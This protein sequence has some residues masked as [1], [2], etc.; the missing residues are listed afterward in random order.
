MIEPTVPSWNSSDYQLL[1]FGGGRK[2]ERLGGIILDRPCPA[3]MIHSAARPSDWPLAR[4]KLDSEGNIV[5]GEVPRGNWCAVFG[6]V[7]FNL[8]ITPFGHVGLFP[9]QAPNWR[10]LSQAATKISTEFHRP[11]RSLNLFA[12]TGGTTL[13]LA[14][15]GA[16]VVHVDAS[17][18]AVKWARS[19]AVSS[20]LNE[21]PIRW[22]VEDARK[23]VARELKRGN[24]YDIV[25]LDP[26]SYG[27]GPS[28]L[29]WSIEQDLQRLLNDCIKLL[30]SPRGL[31]LLTAH[32]DAIDEFVVSGWLREPLQRKFSS[33]MD[34]HSLEH[35][36]LQLHSSHAQSLDAGYFV[37]GSC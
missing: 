17:A 23:F 31:L 37:R 6:P 11:A 3:A 21:R 16:E 25:V 10:W 30:A 22:I 8:K 28:G 2:L 4:A 7:V 5:A 35:G 29:R 33:A 14:N 9:E 13:A 24:A 20:H 12:Y 1:D 34:Q 15:A 19:N 36:R 27:H 18:P 32:S 26:P